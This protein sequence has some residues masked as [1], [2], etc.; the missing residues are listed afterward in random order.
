MI[1][2][3]R[4]IVGWVVIVIFLFIITFGN[5][6]GLEG[7]LGFGAP[8]WILLT[9]WIGWLTIN[10]ILW[11][12]I[13]FIQLVFIQNRSSTVITNPLTVGSNKL[14]TLTEELEQ[15]QKRLNSR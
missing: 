1:H 14:N 2:L 4:I 6:L 11:L 7:I 8:I 12:G 15:E 3:L 13:Q 9:Y 5:P 10:G